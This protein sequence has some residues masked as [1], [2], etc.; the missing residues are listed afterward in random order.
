MSAKSKSKKA[1]RILFWLPA[2]LISLIALGLSWVGWG[3]MKIRFVWWL[4]AGIYT[5]AVWVIDVL[6]D[7]YEDDLTF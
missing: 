6:E 3:L 4:G 1:L 5:V 2:T 7:L